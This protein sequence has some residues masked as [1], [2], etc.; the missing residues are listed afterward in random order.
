MGR[1]YPQDKI[2]ETIGNQD[3]L[4]FGSERDISI[5]IFFSGY[6][7]FLLPIKMF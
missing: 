3:D 4:L 2:W 6:K 7:N 1:I 5:L